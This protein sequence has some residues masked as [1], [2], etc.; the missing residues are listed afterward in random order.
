[1]LMMV[2]TMVIVNGL[3]RLKSVITTIRKD[4]FVASLTTGEKCTM[5]T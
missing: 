1:M 4:S 3:K 2:T 5:T